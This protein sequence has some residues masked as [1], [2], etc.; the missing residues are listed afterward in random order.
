MLTQNILPYSCQYID[1]DDIDEV[2]AA[3]KSPIITRGQRTQE[4]EEQ[5]CSLTGSRYAVLFNSGSSALMAAYYAIGLNP[6]DHVISTPITFVATLSMAFRYKPQ[7]NLLDVDPKT[8]LLDFDQTLE[9]LKKPISRGRFVVVPVHYAG[10][11]FDV[12]KLAVVNSS[13]DSLVI[14]DAAHAFGSKYS[15]GTPVGSCHHSL[16]TMFS[17]HPVKNIT[18]GEGG[19]I[20]TNSLECYEKLC[21]FRNNGVS[22]LSRDGEAFDEPW[23][24]EVTEATGNFHLNDIQAALGISQL[25]K[26]PKFIAKRQKLVATYREQL[27]G[28]KHIELV[29]EEFDPISS[30]HLWPVKIKF[31]S[32]TISKVE[33][34][35]LLQEK[36]IGSQVHYIPLY[37]QPVI[38]EY[39]G[40]RAKE[41]YPGAK[42]AYPGAEEFYEEVLSLPLFHQLKNKEVSHVCETL[43]QIIEAHSLR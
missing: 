12:N 26:L 29:P 7:V 18:T 31:A 3:L 4:L 37:K 34:M 41:A 15:D 8:G 21:L 32:L 30:W 24:Y 23:Y 40:Y 11:T 2:V 20:T 13:L 14:E 42:E 35:R 28:Q 43:K 39:P 36:G 19:A 25:R 17:F 27:Q 33:L 22:K 1:Q 9:V 16:M 38:Q 5:I 6:F 10:M